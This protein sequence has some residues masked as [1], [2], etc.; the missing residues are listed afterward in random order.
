MT[1]T[2]LKAQKPRMVEVVER[3]KLTYPEA[4]GALHFSNPQELLIATILSAQCTDKRVNQVT[5]TLFKKYPSA[6][7][8]LDIPLEVL[9][10]DIFSTGF[11][12][13]KA[14]NIKK[15]CQILVDRY[16]GEVPHAMDE[17]TALGGVGRKTANVVRGN[18][19]GIP[20][21]A[22][23]THVIRL[24]GLLGFT[25]QTNPEKIETDLMNIVPEPDWTALGHLFASHGRATCI[26]R[27]PK[28]EACI[29]SDLCPSAK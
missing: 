29:L 8:F 7:A 1:G 20:G 9:E 26:A 18:A 3:L 16:N 25:K 15:C 27:R 5:E 22:V 23:D 10:K 17:L 13:N 4:K 14:A 28:C 6:Q 2:A 19:F 12:H 24:S 21:V 11:Y